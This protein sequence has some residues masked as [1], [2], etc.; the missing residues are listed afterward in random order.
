MM[1]T[2]STNSRWLIINSSL[3]KIIIVFFI[4][5]FSLNINISYAE[6]FF[7]ILEK[8]NYS[9]LLNRICSTNDGYLVVGT[10]FDDAGPSTWGWAAKIAQDGE[11][12]WEK[13][14]GKK[15]R[16]S[17]FYSVSEN[18]QKDQFVLV[19]SV[20]EVNG[21]PNEV[22]KGWLVKILRNGKIDWDKTINLARTTRIME[23]KRAADG[24]MIAV[25]RLRE[26]SNYSASI[27]NDSGFI[28]KTDV[29]GDIVWKRAI[30]GQWADILYILRDGDL[31]IGNSSW[32]ARTDANGNI[33]WENTLTKGKK[34]NA[35][36]QTNNGNLILSGNCKFS[37]DGSIWLNK[38]NNDG[39]LVLN[40]TINHK[41]FCDIKALK[42]VGSNQ[43]IAMGATCSYAK[44]RIWSAVFDNEFELKSYQKLFIE[45]NVTVR[46]VLIKESGLFV[47]VGDKERKQ[48]NYSAWIFQ[49]KIE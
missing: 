36:T 35:V 8:L 11:I 37:N 27:T 25:G 9:I 44:E 23:V 38:F 28:I 7:K 17:S 33:K 14:F 45:N 30:K 49:G 20:N 32:I 29:K 19:G 4:L 12:Q 2:N 10:I 21:G 6:A 5:A 31:F 41:D 13:E 43:I 34:L 39:T 48:G 16:D 40:K 46:T 26:T 42:S 22:A 1:K 15:A 47:A 24:S 18:A 3:Y